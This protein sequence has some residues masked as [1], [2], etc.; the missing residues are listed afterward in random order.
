MS[1]NRAFPW[2]HKYVPNEKTNEEFIE[3]CYTFSMQHHAWLA[4][5]LPRKDLKLQTH[6]RIPKPY[7]KTLPTSH[8]PQRGPT[9]IPSATHADTCVVDSRSAGLLLA[10]CLCETRSN[11]R[12]PDNA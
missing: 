11:G 1:Q 8:P 10:G 3:F 5:P 9:S 4:N 6:P 12:A 7:K 2:C